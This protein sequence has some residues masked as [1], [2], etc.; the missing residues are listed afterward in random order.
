[1]WLSLLP[2]ANR[3]NTRCNQEESSLQL[4]LTCSFIS[5]INVHFR[6]ALIDFFFFFTSFSLYLNRSPF[7]FPVHRIERGFF[8]RYV[9]MKLNELMIVKIK[10]KRQNEE[11]KNKG[12]IS[13][14]IFLYYLSGIVAF[15]N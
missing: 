6:S 14:C 7:L 2:K 15:L 4:L 8:T 3:L 9:F 1:M 12:K 10:K 13:L 5:L 11:K